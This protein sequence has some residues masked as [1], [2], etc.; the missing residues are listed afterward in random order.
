MIDVGSAVGYLML[1]TAG[2]K[3]GFRSAMDDLRTFQ[4]ESATAGDKFSALGSAMS[5]VG[6]TLT[7]SVTLPLVGVGAAAMAVGNDFEAQMSRVQAIAGATGDELILLKDQALQLGADTAFSAGEAAA[8][9][10]NLASAGFNTEEIMAAMPGLLDLAASSGAEVGKA[11]EIAAS[12]IRGFGLEASE[13]GHV[14]DVFALAAAR[15]NAQTEDMGEAMKYVAPVAK[16]MGQSLEETSAAIGIMSDAGIKGSQAGT[17]L[18]GAMSRL[19]KPTEKMYQVMDELGLSF[20]DTE[21][22][23]LPLNEQIS[24]M[25]TNMAG[26]TQ[27]QKNNALITLFGQESLSG[28]L[29]LIDRG[30]D[31]MIDLTNSFK[32]ADGAAAD[33][34]TTMMDNTKGSID[35]M[36]GSLETFGIKLQEVL[37]PV[38][39]GVVDKMTEFINGLSS[40]DE[41]TLQMIVTIAGA[42]AAIGPLLLIFGKLASAI[43]SISTLIGGAG[44]LSGI[45]TMLTGPIGIII[46]AVAALALAWSTNFGGIRDATASIFESIQTIVSTA[47]D[48]ITGLWDSNFLGIQDIISTWWESLELYWNMIFDTIA[49]IFEVFSLAFQ[50][51]WEGVWDKLKEIV[52][53]I[54]ETIKTLFSNFLNTIVDTLIRIGVRLLKAAKD[55][56]D[57]VMKGFKEIWKNI[58]DW[59]S[60]AI[61]DPVGTIKGIGQALF[62]A[63]ASIFTFLWDGL[64]SIWDKI[65]GWVTDGINWLVSKIKFWEDE[66]EKINTEEAGGKAKISGSFATGLDYVPRDMNVRVH[67]GEAILTKQ[68]NSGRSDGKGDTYNFYSPVALTPVRAAQ[69]MKKA[70]KELAMGFG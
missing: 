33:M 18:R 61:E 32:D 31:A 41:D 34:A 60:K 39:R 7:K 11:S 17:A 38:I 5:S 49:G 66:S 27:E 10:E 15:T 52:S 22:N 20:Y 63:G 29:A 55:A 25:E 4:D 2:F 50:G 30:P 42:V 35:Q 16:A 6:G 28:M 47:L 3:S 46:A 58:T 54:W 24:M 57:N 62:D 26:L 40:M 67:E 53:N 59:F 36:M 14:A 48:F 70:K 68:E 56:F 12:A 65:T 9:M 51:D 37:A 44:G 69:E 1:D 23:M 19:A 21:G 8:G 64:K 45:L 43:G 13:A